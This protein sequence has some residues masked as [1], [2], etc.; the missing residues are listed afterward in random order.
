MGKEVDELLG[1]EDTPGIGHNSS[2]AESDPGPVAA[3]RLKSYV[4]RI[5]RLEEEKK[6]IAEDIKD[7]YT[8]VKAA[9]FDVKI[10]RKAIAL[11]KMEDHKRREEEELLDL[12]LDALGMI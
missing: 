12:Y 1:D 10:V 8:E 9:G 6:V 3:D 7:V 11:R 4:D 2:K 5:E